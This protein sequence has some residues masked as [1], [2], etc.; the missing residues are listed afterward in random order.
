M[1]LKVIANVILKVLSGMPPPPGP[2]WKASVK[3]VDSGIN[4]VKKNLDNLIKI[5]N[6]RQ[7]IYSNPNTKVEVLVKTRMP[8]DKDWSSIL[9]NE[10]R[11]AQKRPKKAE[12][13][14]AQPTKSSQIKAKRTDDTKSVDEPDH[15][16]QA[17]KFSNRTLQ[18]FLKEMRLALKHEDT[19]GQ[20]AKI[21]D[22]LEYVAANLDFER[23]PLQPAQDQL[24]DVSLYKAEAKK[25]KSDNEVLKR[26]LQRL[27]TKTS[28]LEGQVKAKDTKINELKKLISNLT[29]NNK[30]MIDLLTSKAN[31]EDHLQA[32]E[33]ANVRLQQDLT[34]EQRKYAFLESKS[35]SGETEI[36][37]LHKIIE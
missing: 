23:R 17:H 22:D 25:A 35:R 29:S 12:R 36:N 11:A 27:E 33:K 32:L 34:T 18:I 4:K 16:D 21:L 19:K 3:E 28:E 14:F 10:E 5:D 31:L 26:S 30:E 20:V 13:R 6:I 15:K 2:V 1:Y 8:K 9:S 37:R 24:F 7:E